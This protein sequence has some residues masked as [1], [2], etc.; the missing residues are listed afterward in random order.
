MSGSTINNTE[1]FCDKISYILG[2]VDGYKLEIISSSKG[3]VR[4]FESFLA[5]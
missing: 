3:L 4:I 1:T 5:R 2:Y